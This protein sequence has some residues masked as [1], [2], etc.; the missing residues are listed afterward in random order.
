MSWEWIYI[1]SAIPTLTE[2]GNLHVLH[3]RINDPFVCIFGISIDFWWWVA[4]EWEK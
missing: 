3:L 1:P 2:H 4:K